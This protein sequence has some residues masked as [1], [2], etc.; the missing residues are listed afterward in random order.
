[1]I[2]EGLSVMKEWGFVYK[3]GIPWL[4]FV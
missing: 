2:N 4:F 1:M 3:T